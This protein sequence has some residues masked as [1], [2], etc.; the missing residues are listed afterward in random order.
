MSFKKNDR[1]LKTSKH[2]INQQC[3][4][5]EAPAKN[6]SAWYLA[7]CLV[8]LLVLGVFTTAAV[9]AVAPSREPTEYQGYD[10][11]QPWFDGK[12]WAWFLDMYNMPHLKPQEEGSIQTFPT[13]SVPRVGYEPVIP[14]TALRGEKLLRDL[15]PTNPTKADANSLKRGKA[16]FGRYCT[17]C[18]HTDGKSLGKVAKLGMPAPPLGGLIDLLSEAHIYNKIRYGGGYMPQFGPQTTRQERWDIVNYLKKGG[19]KN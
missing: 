16:L 9:I 15:V 5:T 1:P 6:P 10:L 4:V 18:H 14:A 17:P 8:G 2:A 7:G 11:K 13:D 3:T 12:E 19:F